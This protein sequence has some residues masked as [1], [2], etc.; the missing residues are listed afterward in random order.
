MEIRI[1]HR[2]FYSENN[3]GARN[4]F[5]SLIGLK[6]LRH[7]KVNISNDLQEVFRR[8]QFRQAHQSA[9]H[10]IASKHYSSQRIFL[11]HDIMMFFEVFWRCRSYMC[12]LCKPY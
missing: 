4:C 6:I 1:K 12:K 7:D 11:R 10:L 9:L 8:F 3:R 2:I 5:Q